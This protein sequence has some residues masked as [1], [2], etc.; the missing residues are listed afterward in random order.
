MIRRAVELQ[1]AGEP[2][3]EGISEGE[4]LRIGKELGLTPDLVRRAI[5]DVRSK[6]VEEHG[7]LAGLMGA[8]IVR[9]VRT[10]RRPAAP[11]G[12]FLEEYLARC[13]HMA[14]QRRFPD[15]TRYV[16]GTGVAAALG[17]AANKMGSRQAALDLP[18]LDVGVSMVDEDSALVEL[19]VDLS[20]ARTGLAAGGILGGSGAGTSVAVSIWAAHLAT[21]LALVGVPVLAGMVLG[22]RLIYGTLARNTEE[23]LQGFLDRLEHGDVKLPAGKPDW[24]KQLGI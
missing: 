21:P 7:F 10:I 15:R 12:L 17:R 20:T 14:V 3:D 9:A 11:L 5:A 23:K 16:R 8:R 13:E 22:S 4:V 6:P 19:S 1:S 24:R 18:Q 2:G